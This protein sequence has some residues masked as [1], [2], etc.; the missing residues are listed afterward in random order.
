[1]SKGTLTISIFKSEAIFKHYFVAEEMKAMFNGD[2][3]VPRPPNFSTSYE[4]IAFEA[5]KIGKTFVLKQ[6]KESSKR[7]PSLITLYTDKRSSRAMSTTSARSLGHASSVRR[8]S[9]PSMDITREGMDD[10][11]I[12]D[13]TEPLYATSHAGDTRY[14]A[15]FPPE[16]ASYPN[17]ASARISWLFQGTSF[18]CAIN[19][20]P[21]LQVPP[22]GVTPAQV[23]YENLERGMCDMMDFA[24]DTR[25]DIYRPSFNF[26]E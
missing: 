21:G 26:S 5:F 4:Y 3:I 11:N 22:T 23:T 17:I 24:S 12:I 15:G 16:L 10:L 25:L 8:R 2:Y 9:E 13:P 14:P 1:M 20:L 7:E 6:R 19:T 18:T